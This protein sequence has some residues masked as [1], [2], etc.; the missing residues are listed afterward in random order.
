MG[1]VESTR[2]FACPKDH[3][4]LRELD[5]KLTCGASHRYS[6]V[7]GVP[8]L[9]PPDVEQSYPEALRSLRAA[10]GEEE[11][12]N[13]PPVTEGVD[14]FV[15][16]IVGGTCGRMY[17]RLRGRLPDYPIPAISLP[18]GDGASLLDLGCNWGRWCLAAHRAGYR[19]TGIDPSARGILAARRV[20][21]QLGAPD[22]EYYVADAGYL[23][24]PDRSFDVV[25]SYGVFQ[26]LSKEHVVRC[27]EES[28]RVLRPGGRFVA[29]LANLT[30]VLST[31]HLLRR[32][33]TPAEGFEIRY[34]TVS[35]LERVVGRIIGPAEVTAE[36]YFTLNPQTSDLRMFPL[37]FRCLVRTS[38]A[39]KSASR[40]FTPLKYV[41]D[42]LLIRA[43][44]PEAPAS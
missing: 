15:Q 38:E 4:P 2:E 34:W 1:R 20:A 33:F 5:G 41:A 27:L 17:S 10:K 25:F 43:V 36:G 29:Q 37:R 16:R 32:G 22:I 6:F 24:F 11:L 23:P 26:H 35:E 7:H 3:L 39:L 28:A 21:R 31:Y 18:P 42:S 9:M 40:V 19:V 12:E 44:R 14:P 30:C 8:I 13:P